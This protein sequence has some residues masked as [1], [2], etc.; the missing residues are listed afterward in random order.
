MK[1]GI[2][3]RSLVAEG[4]GERE[5]IMLGQELARRGTSVTFYVVFH[6]TACYPKLL[7]K[8]RIVK[9]ENFREDR[10]GLFS[11]IPFLRSILRYFNEEKNAKALARQIGSDTKILNPHD[12]FSA[13]VAHYFKKHVKNIPSIL[14][15]ND[16][17]ILSWTL[18]DDPLFNLPPKPSWKKF[19]YKIFD[20]AWTKHFF[21][22]QDAIAVLNIRTKEIMK[23][24]LNIDAEVVRSGLDV[25]EFPYKAR[26][27]PEDRKVK[28]LSNGIFYIHR[29]FEDVIR[30]VKILVD[31]GFD[32]QLKITGDWRHK[33]IAQ[34]YYENLKKL[35]EDL[36]VEDH[37]KFAGLISADA[38]KQCYYEA[39]ILVVSNHMQT[40]GLLVFEAMSTGLPV[41]L[42]R[43][44]GAA[45]VLRDGEEVLMADPGSPKQIAEAVR[46]LIK[47]KELY[48][49]LS[50]H[51]AEFVR[52]HISWERYADQMLKL[53]E[54]AKTKINQ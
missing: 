16:L 39:D 24:Y 32:P 22:K 38:L 13:H 17:H 34:K 27:A 1:I 35:V 49:K 21:K 9:L 3:I 18:F 47:D 41:V 10:R 29:R 19:L 11:H 51:G 36:G 31:S 12:E 45:E 40:W 53:F 33:D 2:I 4:G 23:R 26:E 43:S 44:V 14:M 42:S 28:L 30:A 25:A 8:F 54:S 6:A 20:L 52:E 46:K 48:K 7:S 37:V 5:A 50:R 15:L